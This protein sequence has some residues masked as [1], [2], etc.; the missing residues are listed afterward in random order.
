L[1]VKTNFPEIFLDIGNKRAFL[2][3]NLKFQP[4]PAVTS[5]V[6]DGECLIGQGQDEENQR[7]KDE[8]NDQQA[9]EN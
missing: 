6:I 8:C 4:Y 5:P 9:G 2:D 7:D 1:K 3:K